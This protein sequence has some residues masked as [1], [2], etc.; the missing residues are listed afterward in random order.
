VE[1]GLRV[2]RMTYENAESG[3]E[4]GSYE[5]HDGILEIRDLER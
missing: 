3:D 5:C 2:L 4:S 1:E